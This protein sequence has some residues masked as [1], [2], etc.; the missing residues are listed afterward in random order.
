MIL[1]N[2]N[3]NV[4]HTVLQFPQKQLFDSEH[5]LFQVDP[6]PPSSWM[7]SSWMQKLRVARNTLKAA[8]VG[9]QQP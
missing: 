5:P 9:H 4:P 8:G 7:A 1:G 3:R 6:F 2:C